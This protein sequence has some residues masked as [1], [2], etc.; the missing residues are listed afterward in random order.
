[1]LDRKVSAFHQFSPVMGVVAFRK[2]RYSAREKSK[3]DSLVEV[4]S[5]LGVSFGGGND[6]DDCD[7]GGGAGGLKS[8]RIS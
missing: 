4:Q 6:D 8:R 5:F 1:M 7:G 3:E 2:R